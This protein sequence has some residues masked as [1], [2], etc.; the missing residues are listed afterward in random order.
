MK[1]GQSA[2]QTR[3]EKMQWTLSCSRHPEI[4]GGGG[5]WLSPSSGGKTVREGHSQ[6]DGK[7]ADWRENSVAVRTILGTK[8]A[9]CVVMSSPPLIVC[10]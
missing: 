10:K 3:L 6:P 4:R 9:A 2:G 8:E 5:R 1:G 7:Q